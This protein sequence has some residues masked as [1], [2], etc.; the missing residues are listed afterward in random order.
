MSSLTTPYLII[1]EAKIDKPTEVQTYKGS[2]KKTVPNSLAPSA[3]NTEINNVTR[4]NPESQNSVTPSKHENKREK[5][6]MEFIK[7][8]LEKSR[9]KYREKKRMQEER[10]LRCGTTWQGRDVTSYL[11]RSVSD[12]GSLRPR[13]ESD[14]FTYVYFVVADEKSPTSDSFMQEQI[15]SSSDKQRR[16]YIAESNKRKKARE[17]DNA[18][19]KSVSHDLRLK[20][21]PQNT[22]SEV[23]SEKLSQTPNAV[24]K[25][26]EGQKKVS[27][28]VFPFDII[29][30]P[31]NSTT[32]PVTT[33]SSLKLE[34]NTDARSS[35]EEKMREHGENYNSEIGYIEGR[36]KNSSY[37]VKTFEL[38]FISP[39]QK[40]KTK[41]MNKLKKSDEQKSSKKEVTCAEPIPV[42]RGKT[43]VVRE[44]GTENLETLR[45]G[46]RSKTMSDID[47]DAKKSYCQKIQNE[48]S[49]VLPKLR[50]MGLPLT[51][52]KIDIVSKVC[53]DMV[54]NMIKCY[55]HD[56]KTT[57]RQ[58]QRASK[59]L[60][61]LQAQELEK[62]KQSFERKEDD[63]ITSASSPSQR[64]IKPASREANILPQSD[65]TLASLS[66]ETL[67]KHIASVKIKFKSKD[68]DA[69]AEGQSFSRHTG[70][71][72]VENRHK[73]DANVVPVAP[74]YFKMSPPGLSR[75]NT[76]L[77]IG[78]KS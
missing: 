76:E 32:V 15:F 45:M 58:A 17:N 7:Y 34:D 42:S 68:D 12:L 35:E 57:S 56:P 53:V 49:V 70:V 39:N 54:K 64:T 13:R 5:T 38:P 66:E 1:T 48:P 67:E 52:P 55:L 18:K 9:E 73:G 69:T 43:F 71:A 14:D 8:K 65:R 22:D 10:G 6:K 3:T 61:H 11:N 78:L 25:T 4:E 47:I 63:T 28:I 27:H 62:E 37:T 59:L 44:L 36:P 72:A 29:S 33:G 24:D 60:A 41:L 51:L 46:S 16:H 26:T 23:K 74:T 30:K 21:N 40:V 2:R 75:E 77:T 50:K 20:S 19:I 31:K